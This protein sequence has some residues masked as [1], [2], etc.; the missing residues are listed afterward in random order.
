MDYALRPQL[1]SRAPADERATFL[2]LTYGHLAGAIL[3]FTLLEMLLF[4]SGAAEGIIQALFIGSGLSMLFLL[5]GFIAAGWLAQY[6]ARSDQPLGVQY[7][8]LGLYV[9]AEVVIFLPLLY[10]AV[11][12]TDASV[13]PTA[14]VL[15]LAMFGGFTAAG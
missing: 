9:V 6:W 1:A 15:T 13:L 2:R 7:L 4:Q 11:H 3:V 8:G 5:G 10:I 12:F 14:V